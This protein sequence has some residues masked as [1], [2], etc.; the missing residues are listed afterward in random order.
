MNPCD[1]FLWGYLKSRI[2]NPLPKD[3]DD[4]KANIEREKKIKILAMIY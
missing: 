4:L 3:L 2:Y 1:Y